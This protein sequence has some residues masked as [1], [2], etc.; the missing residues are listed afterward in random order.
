MQHRH[1]K[2]RT[3]KQQGFTLIEL[4]VVIAI[5]SILAAILFPVFA[6]AKEKGR[7]A[8]C[9]SNLKQFM[10][11]IIMYTNDYDEKMPLSIS[12][13][14]QVGPATAQAAGIPEFGVHAEIMPY[15]KNSGVFKCPDDPGF[16]PGAT[17]KCGGGAVTCAGDTI[18]DA[19]GTS[20]KFTKE[21]FSIFPSTKPPVG[22]YNCTTGCAQTNPKAK[23]L[24]G[25]DPPFPMPIAF[26]Q[27][28]A[29]TRVMRCFVAP[30]E[31]TPAGGGPIPAGKPAV[32]HPDGEMMTFM[33]GHVKWVKSLDQEN[34]Y[35]NG[36]TYSPVRALPPSDPN[37]KANGDGSCG[38]ERVG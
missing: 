29:E 21:N 17:P 18:A 30:W 28:P 32:F 22:N 37:Y 31:E 33:D 23:L 11:A 35:C 12:G 15:V 27:R 24:S 8:V 38:A 2:H 16:K 25:Q 14:A 5:I 9:Q 13:N 6:T 4:L 3:Y 26:F 34:S 1:N 7:Q 19:Y 36:P 20:Y 10:G